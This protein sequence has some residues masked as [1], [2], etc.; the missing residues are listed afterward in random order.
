MNNIAEF[1]NS[2]S[3]PDLISGIYIPQECHCSATI[4]FTDCIVVQFFL[5]HFVYGATVVNR[6][7][8]MTTTTCHERYEPVSTYSVRQ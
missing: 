3:P 7:V 6:A 1:I 2:L 5:H 4:T 8:T